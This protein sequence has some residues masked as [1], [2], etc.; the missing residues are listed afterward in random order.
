MENHPIRRGACVKFAC[1]VL[2]AGLCSVFTAAVAQSRPASA[3]LGGSWEAN[4]ETADRA[5]LQFRFVHNGGPALTGNFDAPQWKT[6]G[7]AIADGSFNGDRVS[8][9]VVDIDAKFSG[10]LNAVHDEI[11]GE[12]TQ[13]GVTAPLVLRK[14]KSES[15]FIR[16]QDPQPPFPY[17][18]EDLVLKNPKTGL[19]IGGTLTWP[20]GTRRFPLIVLLSDG[21][22]HDRNG[23]IA[24]HHLLFVLS[25]R[26]TRSGF[27]TWRMDDRGVDD[28][29]GDLSQATFDD[30]ANDVRFVIQNLGKRDEIDSDH[31]GIVAHG[32]GGWAA[33]RAANGAPTIRFLLLMNTPMLTG[34][35]TEFVRI[36][37]LASHDAGH[38]RSLESISEEIDLLKKAAALR[39]SGSN[40]VDAMTAV[41]ELIETTMSKWTDEDLK[42]FQP[43]AE[44]SA[45]LAQRLFTPHTRDAWKFDPIA[46]LRNAKYAVLLIQGGRD[47]EVP[48]TSHQ[49]LIA[50]LAKTKRNIE[51]EGG[52]QWNHLLQYTRNYLVSEYGT[53]DETIAPEALDKILQWCRKHQ[54]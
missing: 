32:E 41:K 39:D 14:I 3:D 24:G 1:L 49:A 18:Q 34:D 54:E 47:V 50:A 10:R 53:I 46:E 16:P 12:W 36:S 19:L 9:A 23:S 31:I 42:G 15:R 45:N 35:E 20:P 43:I 25:D 8:F 40:A 33:M 51:V 4:L 7:I 48:P 37:S 44:Y 28:S 6:K 52:E 11:S 38:S 30:L 5:L 17:L 13:W 21:G 27:A 22:P 2:W 26:L 29:S